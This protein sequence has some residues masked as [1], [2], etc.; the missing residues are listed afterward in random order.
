M[1]P[2]LVTWCRL[3]C[4]GIV[5]TT[6]AN[7]SGSE[8]G[9]GDVPPRSTGRGLIFTYRRPGDRSS[10]LQAR[11]APPSLPQ[12]QGTRQQGVTRPPGCACRRGPLRH[13]RPA[14]VS[15]PYLAHPLHAPRP[16]AH[17]CPCP[18]N[19]HRSTAPAPMHRISTGFDASSLRRPA[20][21]PEAWARVLGARVAP[22]RATWVCSAPHAPFARRAARFGRP[23]ASFS[24]VGAAG[25][26]WEHLLVE[27]C[28]LPCSVLR[29][30]ISERSAGVAS[31]LR[32]I[33]GVLSIQKCEYGTGVV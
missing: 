14:G 3:L 21:A 28:I 24:S 12:T 30:V 6:L 27:L 33:F 32:I 11:P 23:F 22:R 4:T 1:A 20:W 7:D 13:Q 19:P 10:P 25:W 26:L 16:A 15:R 17:A 5:P 18:R 9:A 31:V 8:L 29:D 2:C